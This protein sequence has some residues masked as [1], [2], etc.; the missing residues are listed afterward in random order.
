MVAVVSEREPVIICTPPCKSWRH[1]ITLVIALLGLTPIAHAQEREASAA[2]AITDTASGQPAAQTPPV[3]E[4][5]GLVAIWFK[6]IDDFKAF[7]KRESTWVIL[8][9]GG[10]GAALAHPA[11]RTLNARLVGSTAAERFW[12]PGHIVGSDY[13]QIG[14]AVGLYAI[15][16]YVVPHDDTERTNKLSHL[17]FDLLRAQLVSQAFS[18]AIKVTVQRDRPTGNCCGFPS[19]HAMATFATAAVLER[20]LGYRA[21]WPTLALATYVATSR[22]HDNVH[23]LSDVVFGAALGTAAGWT[24]VGTHG[25]SDFTM[26]P[27]PIRRGVMLA[28]VRG[29]TE[30]SNGT[31]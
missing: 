9:I 27:I 13:V 28:F 21:A 26:M 12:V 16:R 6:T 11:D 24:V 19:G 18:E 30:G 23:Y 22:L 5:T 14:A 25:R 2:G 7:P 29:S 1:A 10:A 17:G 8:G 20:H 31:R 4:H 3:P 15:G